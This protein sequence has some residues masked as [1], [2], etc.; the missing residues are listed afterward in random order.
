MVDIPKKVLDLLNDPKSV[1]VFATACD[2]GQPHAIAAGSIASPSPDKM[3]VGEILMKKSV[4][5]L[6]KNPKAS[7][8]VVNGMSS[9]Q[10]VVEKPVRIESGPVLDKMNEALAAIKLHA[11]AVWMFDVKEVYEQGAN[12]DAGK[13]IA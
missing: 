4:E 1:K 8:L 10:I 3:M 9:Y 2:C 12:M 11:N 6:Q 7:F 5:N 13:K